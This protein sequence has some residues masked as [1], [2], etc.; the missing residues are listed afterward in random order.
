MARF[1]GK[2]F[3]ITGGTS[4]IGLAGARRIA[5]EGGQVVVTGTNPQRLADTQK[6]LPDAQVLRNDASD[7]SAAD[8]LAQSVAAA[9]GLDGLWLNAGYAAVAGVDEVDADFFDR[10]M[11]ANVR[12]PVLQL[13]RLSEHLSEGASVVVTSST[14]TYEG[15]AMT[16]VYAATK[17][18]LVAMA[19]AWATELAG[20][21]IR[22]NV[23][24][25]GAISTNFRDFMSEDVREDFE[26]AVV[27]HVPLGRIGTADEAA[28]VALFLLSDESGYVTASQYAVD[29]G[30]TMR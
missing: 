8:A 21:G 30:L 6:A 20:R 25:P 27:G 3:L 28:A 19:R 18:A 23:L 24:V 4:G 7:P 26:T 15:A 16:S 17:G 22:V 1:T 9:G 14:S 10:M 11:N 2:R 13:A 5:A 12:G 29:G